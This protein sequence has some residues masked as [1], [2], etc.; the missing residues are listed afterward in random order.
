MVP[1]FFEQDVP[2]RNRTTGK[3]NMVSL[4]AGFWYV[5]ENVTGT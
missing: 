4:L 1:N 5:L 2:H 3:H